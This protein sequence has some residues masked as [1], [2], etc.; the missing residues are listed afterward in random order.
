VSFTEVERNHACV[1]DRFTDECV[2]AR[3]Q[4]GLL[5]T[6]WIIAY[7]IHDKFHILRISNLSESNTY[8]YRYTRILDA[9]Y[10]HMYSCINIYN[11]YICLTL[12]V[13]NCIHTKFKT[14]NIHVYNFINTYNV[15]IHLFNFICIKLYIYICSL[16]S[17]SIH[18]MKHALWAHTPMHQK[19]WV[20]T[21]IN[22]SGKFDDN[23]K[24]K[25]LK[26]NCNKISR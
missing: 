25:Y 21:I 9:L 23:F 24:T 5:Y 4:Q 10:I 15:Y 18:K 1:F 26:K 12:Y 17:M 11:L 22:C 13:S 3:K 6:G 19:G 14:C 16:A 8:N 7:H 20:G 2:P